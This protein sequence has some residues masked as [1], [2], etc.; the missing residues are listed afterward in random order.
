MFWYDGSQLQFSFYALA[1]NVRGFAFT[2][3][4]IDL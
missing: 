4:N 2:M 3:H 1:Q